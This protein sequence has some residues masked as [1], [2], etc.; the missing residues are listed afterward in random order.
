MDAQTPLDELDVS[1]RTSEFLADLGVDTVGELLALP[2][3]RAPRMIAAELQVIIDELG[4]EYRGRIIVEAPPAMEATGDVE[5]RWNT[6]RAWLEDGHADALEMFHGPAAPEAIA[7]AERELGRT[8]PDDYR[9]FLVLH[10]GQDDGAP[11]VGSCALYPVGTLAAEY[12]WLHGLYEEEGT[13]DADLAGTGVR[14]VQCARGW[15]PIGRSARGRDFLCLDLEP[16]PGGRS[17]QIIQLSVDL[18][19]RP[20]IAPSFADLLSVFFTQLQTGE[21]E[22]EDS[23]DDELDDGGDED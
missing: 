8:L 2:E 14:P 5:Q 7:N 21:I 10:D 9:R 20:L 15:I 3:I 22:V 16:A 11:M 12:E 13:I 18:D 6:I 4:L 1:V 23:D 19:D 17:G